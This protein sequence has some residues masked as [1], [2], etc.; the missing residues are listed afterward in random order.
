MLSCIFQGF[1]SLMD[2]ALLLAWLMI[3]VKIIFKKS[4][5]HIF[6]DFAFGKVW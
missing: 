2:T 3:H 5:M 4:Q 1:H 6:S